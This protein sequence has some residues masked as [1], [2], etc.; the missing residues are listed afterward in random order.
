MGV[1]ICCLPLFRDGV[2]DKEVLHIIVKML[3]RF[4]GRVEDLEEALP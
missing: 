4:R 1:Q 3:E 2:R